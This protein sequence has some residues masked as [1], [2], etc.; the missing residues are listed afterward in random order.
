MALQPDGKFVVAGSHQSWGTGPSTAF[1]IARYNPDGSRDW[2]NLRLGVPWPH[3]GTP[4]SCQASYM[5][6]SVHAVAVQPDGKIIAAG[7]AAFGNVPLVEDTKADFALVRVNPD[8]TSDPTFG[9][10]GGLR[11]RVAA[12]HDVITEITLQPDGKIVAAG[13]AGRVRTAF[14][15]GP[16]QRERFRRHDL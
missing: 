11:H 4:L 3:C 9:V 15:I 16:V 12:D 2:W 8:G 1:A 13:C 5:F 7:N 6:S 14:G 10:G